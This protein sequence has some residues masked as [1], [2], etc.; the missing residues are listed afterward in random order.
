MRVGLAFFLVGL[1]FLV[2]ENAVLAGNPFLS[3]GKAEKTEAAEPRADALASPPPVQGL[4]AF[5]AP[6]LRVTNAWQKELKSELTAFARDMKTEPFGVSFFLF[7][8]LSFIY[9]VV[10][11]IGPGHGKSVVMSY[12][13]NRPGGLWRGF[14]MGHLITAVHVASGAAI[15][16][17]MALILDSTRVADFEAMSPKM[18]AVSYTLVI[19]IGAYLAVH[20]ALD[21]RRKRWTQKEEPSPGD[22]RGLLLTSVVTGLVPCPGAALILLFSVI[23]DVLFQGLLAMF[24]LAMGMGLTTSGFALLAIGSRRTVLRAAQ[25][26]E[27][28]FVAVY[29]VLSFGGAF[30]IV[31]LGS[32]MLYGTGWPE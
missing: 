11:A 14:A 5:L 2:A 10:H 1:F 28:A 16:L 17:V 18:E 12:F 15:I 32:L 25:R 7:L 22:W 29:A 30:A 23:L 24:F 9:G 27:K 13:L 19:L 26:N 31:L 8:L 21:L 20:A 3:K 4:P 6:V